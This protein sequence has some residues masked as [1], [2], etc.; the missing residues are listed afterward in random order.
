MCACAKQGLILAPFSEGEVPY[1]AEINGITQG[2]R[3]YLTCVRVAE[4]GPRC[5]TTF[6]LLHAQDS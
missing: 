3:Y 6:L 5:L 1:L 4:Y 2:V